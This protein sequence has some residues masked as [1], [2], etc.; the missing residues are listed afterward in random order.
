MR[1]LL[2]ATV[3]TVLFFGAYW[4]LMRRETRFTMVRF[5]LLGTLLLALILPLI[6]LPLLIP[7]NYHNS[8]SESPIL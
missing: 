3:G 5:Y 4:L 6:H 7:I 8:N 1:Y 2:F